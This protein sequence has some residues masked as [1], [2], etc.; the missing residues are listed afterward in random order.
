MKNNIIGECGKHPGHNMVNCAMCQ[1]ESPITVPQG[2][3][4]KDY[5]ID[6]EEFL[7]SLKEANKNMRQEKKVEFELTVF[8][9]S[10]KEFSEEEI[11]VTIMNALRKLDEDSETIVSK[12]K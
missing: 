12:R 2:F 4:S 6:D 10:K 3:F 5:R 8:Y 9:S 1:I 11:V 7:K